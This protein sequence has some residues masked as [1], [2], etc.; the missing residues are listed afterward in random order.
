MSTKQKYKVFINDQPIHFVNNTNACGESCTIISDHSQIT[1]VR[2][3]ECMCVLGDDPKTAWKNFT[4]SY[5]II[6]AAGG[7]VWYGNRGNKLLLIYRLGKWDLPKG[8]IDPGE[9]PDVAALREVEEECG[10]SG[11]KIQRRVNDTWHMYCHKGSWKLKQTCWYEM[12]YNGPQ[13]LT[14]QT[15]EAIE[16]AQWVTPQELSY[17]LPLTYTSI[18]ELLEETVTLK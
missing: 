6:I 15:D 13:E 12:I 11:M 7:I 1:Q 5:K 18:R 4:E 9:S 14:P 3:G 10:I 17:L 2:H 16:K 8:K